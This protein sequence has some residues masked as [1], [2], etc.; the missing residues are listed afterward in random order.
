M[1]VLACYTVPNCSDDKNTIKY[2]YPIPYWDKNIPKR[3]QKETVQTNTGTYYPGI[4][5]SRCH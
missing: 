2:P 5:L 1:K 3:Y 4:C